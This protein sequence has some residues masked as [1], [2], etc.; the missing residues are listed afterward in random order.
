MAKSSAEALA[1]EKAERRK[2]KPG[3]ARFRCQLKKRRV[4]LGLSLNDVATATNLTAQTIHNAERGGD[5]K[6]SKALVL[7]R[8]YAATIEELW[9]TDV[10]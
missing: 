1:G 9:P 4:A 10:P 2:A 3:R 8:F 7:S 6:L 5:M